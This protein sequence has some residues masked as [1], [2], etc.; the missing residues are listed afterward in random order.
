VRDREALIERLLPLRGQYAEDQRKLAFYSEAKRLFD[1]LHVARC[2]ACLERLPDAPAI[3]SGQCTLCGQTPDD[4]TQVTFDR[5]KER[6]VLQARIRDL[7]TYTT[8]V[9]AQLRQARAELEARQEAETRLAG[10]LD[11]KT[12]SEL[13]PFVAQRDQIFRER[14]RLHAEHRDIE[15]M[16]RWLDALARREA[17]VIQ[18]TA[19]LQDVADELE[20]L[21]SNVPDRDAVVREVSDRFAELLV[22][23]GFPKV[24]DPAAPYVDDRFI[25]H[26][27]GRVYREIGSDGAMTLTALAWML[28]IFEL[29]VERG[30][31]H[32]GFL[33]IDSPQKNLAPASGQE[34]DDYMD[35]AIVERFYEHLLTWAARHPGAQVVL[36]DHEPSAA[37]ADNVVVR[38][39]RRADM[40]PYGLIDDRT[41]APSE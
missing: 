16:L 3:V 36:V 27:R 21:R 22:D 28:A 8:Q 12:A 19:R 17:N 2:P 37:A 24:H 35:P 33:M 26:V 31:P 20:Q 34:V 14:Q 10:E 18:L 4:D 7:D 30:A 32:P 40:P 23:W 1:P 29:A 11:A 15:R 6:R 9:D 39:T 38:Y 13:S 5:E 41:D 25:P